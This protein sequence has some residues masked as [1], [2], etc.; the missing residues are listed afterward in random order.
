[1]VWASKDIDYRKTVVLSIG[2]PVKISGG[3]PCIIPTPLR[4]EMEKGSIKTV[5]IVLTILN[6]YRVWP[7]ARVLKLETI[8]DPFRGISPELPIVEL[9]RVIKLLP[10]EGFPSK[11]R[12]LNITTAGPNFKISSL[13][14]PFD[15]FTF[16]LYPELL[17]SLEGYSRASKNMEF[18][19]DFEEECGRIQE[20]CRKN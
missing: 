5:K 1:M 10:F 16:A 12:G 17:A 14:A 18:F 19:H 3:L 7:C 11:A 9:K 4:R 20:F 2:V 6:L 8:T 15:A 13:S